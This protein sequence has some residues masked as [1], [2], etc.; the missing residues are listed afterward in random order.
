MNRYYICICACIATLFCSIAINIAG[1]DRPGEIAAMVAKSSP[2]DFF[3]SISS[4]GWAAPIIWS[5]WHVDHV[6]DSKARDLM[7]QNRIFGR[8]FAERLEIWATDMRKTKNS[9]QN[10][11]DATA[12]SDIADWLASSSGYENLFLA[13]RVKDIA[14]IGAGKVVVDLNT[15]FDMASSLVN[16]LVDTPWAS[17]KSRAEVLNAEAGE[18]LFDVSNLSPTEAEKRLQEI[19]ANGHLTQLMHDNPGIPAMLEGRSDEMSKSISGAIKKQSPKEQQIYLK[20]RDFFADQHITANQATLLR[21]WDT[22]HHK[23]LIIGFDF[24]NIQA[25]K[26]L[27]DFRSAVGFFPTTEDG[28]EKE[29][30]A[31]LRGP[32]QIIR[33]IEKTALFD[34]AW[35]A[36]KE[37]TAGEFMDMDARR[38]RLVEK[39]PSRAN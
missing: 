26:A 38:M 23:G 31:R 7:V 19:W 10:I 25:V 34:A 12:L 11:A 27:L 13:A 4:N 22:K 39:S 30:I 37:I 21:Q 8:V 2:A 32:D 33:D 28:F 36:Y 29:W 35:R 20:N 15:P 5:K 9:S 14:A 18:N 6:R 16:R 24:R 17:A 1:Q 3:R